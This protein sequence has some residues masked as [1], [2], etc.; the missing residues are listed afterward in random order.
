MTQQEIDE[1]VNQLQEKLDPEQFDELVAAVVAVV[2][3][4]EQSDV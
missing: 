3:E 1:F 2:E 4:R